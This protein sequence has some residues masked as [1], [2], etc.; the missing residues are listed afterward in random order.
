[1]PDVPDERRIIINAKTAREQAC[2]EMGFLASTFVEVEGG[3]LFEIPHRNLLDADQ[4]ER[5]EEMLFEI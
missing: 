5:Y 3:E 4:Q 2:D 1:M